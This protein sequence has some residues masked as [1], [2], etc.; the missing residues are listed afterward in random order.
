MILGNKSI[1]FA[2]AKLLV[3]P[4]SWKKMLEGGSNSKKI[5][6][7]CP[8]LSHAL[9]RISKASGFLIFMPLIDLNDAIYIKPS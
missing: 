1:W 4:T 6:R 7:S 2:R 9:I 5:R 3:K 8:V